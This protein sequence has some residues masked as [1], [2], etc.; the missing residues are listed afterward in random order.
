MADRQ[1]FTA[2]SKTKAGEPTASPLQ[3]HFVAAKALYKGK[4]VIFCSGRSE[5][6]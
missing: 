3:F 2:K 6:G 4:K 5:Y 1:L